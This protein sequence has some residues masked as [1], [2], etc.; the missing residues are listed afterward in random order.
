MVV[1]PHTIDAITPL[2]TEHVTRVGSLTRA[3]TASSL[4][5]RRPTSGKSPSGI[6][7]GSLGSGSCSPRWSL[8]EQYV[9]WGFTIAT[10]LPEGHALDYRLPPLGQPMQGCVSSPTLSQGRVPSQSSSH[11]QADDTLPQFANLPY[12]ASTASPDMKAI[13]GSSRQSYGDGIVTTGPVA[14]A[15]AQRKSLR[16]APANAKGQRVRNPSVWQRWQ[17]HSWSNR[18]QSE[19]VL[20]RDRQR[21]RAFAFEL[22]GGPG[23]QAASPARSHAASVFFGAGSNEVLGCLAPGALRHVAR[24]H[25]RSMHLMPNSLSYSHSPGVPGASAV[26]QSAVDSGTG[27]EASNNRKRGSQFQG[28]PN[29]AAGRRSIVSAT[30]PTDDADDLGDSGNQQASVIRHEVEDLPDVNMIWEQEELAQMIRVVDAYVWLVLPPSAKAASSPD[31]A[32]SATLQSFSSPGSP[33][34]GHASAPPL[35][36]DGLLLNDKE[37]P[38]VLR[39]IFCRFLLASKLCGDLGAPHRYHECV[40]AF[41]QHASRF[42]SFTGMPRNLCL[43]VLSG[44]ALPPHL[45]GILMASTMGEGSRFVPPEA[46]EFFNTSLRVAMAH[47]EVRRERID[48]RIAQLPKMGKERDNEGEADDANSNASPQELAKGQREQKTQKD[49][50]AAD[51]GPPIVWPPLPPRSVAERDLPAWRLGFQQWEEELGQQNF[52]FLRALHAHSATVVRGELLSSQLLEPEVLHFATRFRPLFTAL[53]NT[54]ADEHSSEPEEVMLDSV[55]EATALQSTAPSVGT[56][57]RIPGAKMFPSDLPQARILRRNAGIPDEMSFSAFFRFCS[58]FDLFPR[59]ASFDEIK[60]V[61]DDAECTHEKNVSK[62]EVPR[63][64]TTPQASAAAAACLPQVDFAIFDKNAAD[65]CDL[66]LKTIYFFAAVEEWLSSRCLRLADLVIS[67]MP[68][69]LEELEEP[70]P[71]PVRRREKDKSSKTLQ[72]SSSVVQGSRPGSAMGG[73]KQRDAKS[74]NTSNSKK[75]GQPSLTGTSSATEK[76]PIIQMPPSLRI[77]AHV[78]LEIAMPPGGSN[79]LSEEELAK[80]FRLLLGLVD[81]VE[82]VEISVYQLDK[83]LT[84]ARDTTERLRHTCCPLLASEQKL[85]LA[86]KNCCSFLE[87]LD[88][89]LLDRAVWD[90]GR[91]EDLFEDVT[92]LTAQDF[93][94]KAQSVGVSPERIP[95]REELTAFL[96]KLGGRPGNGCIARQTAYQVLSMVNER[97]R[98]RR[99]AASK[100]KLSFAAEGAKQVLSS[101]P[102]SAMMSSVDAGCPAAALPGQGAHGQ[103]TPG[104]PEVPL[105]GKADGAKGFGCS[106]F[107]ECLLKLVLHRL[108]AKGLSEIQRGAPSW[109]KCTWL[110]TLLNGSFNERVRVHRH[111]QRLMEF[112][113]RE[114]STHGMVKEA[115]T[116]WER[117]FNAPLPRHVP[118]PERLAASVPDIFDPSRAEESVLHK[119]LC[120]DESVAVPCKSCKEPRSPNGW[121]SP[122]CLFCAGIEKLC[123]PFENHIFAP[124]LR[125]RIVDPVDTVDTTGAD[126]SEVEVCDEG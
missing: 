87:A 38:L 6:S 34:G 123:F 32:L 126:Q 60:Q 74:D 116:W 50:L 30:F 83:V 99:A 14:R 64:K 59:H 13:P 48:D 118:S 25:T 98:C 23:R 10:S 95:S 69:V 49:S 124:L 66:E 57:Q 104:V 79:L 121:G 67:C 18:L 22:C 91:T 40:A 112:A 119:L 44:I 73:P 88:Q 46:Q 94:D 105:P 4:A 120:E 107:V 47:C 97:R 110:L 2:S 76:T 78:F 54:Y 92:F 84:K 5:S 35:N 26:T 51:R 3:S 7:A 86:D 72:P 31:M 9:R 89:Q 80:S 106:A 29:G 77:T 56:K 58:D 11:G 82:H 85:S 68:H 111:R 12:R 101:V 36:E 62:L 15:A 70:P 24:P 65:M 21:Q 90:D 114:P 43:R 16:T 39:P 102:S 93:I 52:A 113:S 20:E 33:S 55:G 117:I 109:W 125:T 19:D 8:P 63:R 103:M 75:D 71:R 37:G 45:E 28:R 1:L 108:G 27:A 81:S 122:G 53:F 42:E 61:Y 115:D 100:A 17:V 41:D 96:V